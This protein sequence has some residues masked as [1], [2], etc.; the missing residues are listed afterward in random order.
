MTFIVRL[1]RDESG[2]LR[3]MVERVRTGEKA[4]VEGLEVIAG[5]IAR[6]AADEGDWPP[7]DEQG[8]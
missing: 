5:V 8:S 3:G 2:R 1:T 4:P 7:S 6:M